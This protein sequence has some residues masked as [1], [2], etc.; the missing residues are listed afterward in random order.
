MQKIRYFNTSGP[1]IPAKHYTLF[2]TSLVEKGIKLVKDER[3]F[4]IWAPRQTGKSTYFRLLANELLKDGYKVCHI[5]I[6]NFQNTTESFVCKFISERLTRDWGVLI[7]APTFSELYHEISKRN[8]F[9]GVFIIDE[10]EGLNQELFGQF[11]HT[12]RNAYHSRAE[13]VLKSVILVGVSNITGVVQDN[14]SPFNISDNLEVPYFTPN[15]I[16]ELLGQHETETNQRFLEAVKQKIAHITA[17]QPGL[18][19][20]FAEKLISLYED[21]QVIDYEQYLAVEDWYLYEALDKNVANIINK[22]KNYQLFMEK[23]LF[24]EGN[25]RFDIDKEEHRYLHVNGIIHK[26]TAG[27][28]EFWVPLYKK[29]IQKYFYPTMNGEAAEI[30]GNI[31][32]DEYF[33]AAGTLNMDKIIRGYQEYAARRG[34]RYFIEKDAN[35][36]PKGL[37]EA[38]LM[39]SFETY[40]QSFLQVLKGKSYLEP[41]VALGRSDLIVNIRGQEMVIEGKIYYNISQFADGKQQLAY[42]IHSLGLKEGVYLVFVNSKVRNA[43]VVESVEMLNFGSTSELENIKISTYIVPYDIEKDFSENRKSKD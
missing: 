29:R 26:N 35:G 3:Y 38:A 43:K 19:N 22:A 37:L 12:I 32:I 41:H 30:Q 14:A 18:V 34:F 39:Y 42:Y 8:D 16:F 10:V 11:L 17:G 6:E 2:R 31:D 5:N 27:N 4:T 40:I 1:N 20:G 21:L 33:T 36:K 28:I 9:H 13:H 7:A 24:T 23:L 25:I 15:E